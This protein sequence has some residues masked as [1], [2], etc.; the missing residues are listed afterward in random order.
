MPTPT[1]PSHSPTYKPND[2]PQ[3][4]S[5]SMEALREYFMRLDFYNRRIARTPITSDYNKIEGAGMGLQVFALKTWFAQGLSK[6]LAKPYT[7]FK[8]ELIRR[9]VPADFVWTQLAKLHRLRQAPGHDIDAFQEFSDQMRSLQM[10]IG[11]QVV[12]DQEVAKLVLLGTDPELCR[13][14]RTHMVS[15]LAGWSD[16][17][18]EKL[19]LDTPV[20]PTSPEAAEVFSDAHTDQPLEFD[21]QVFERIGREEWSRPTYSRPAAASAAPHV[22]TAATGHSPITGGP[23]P[24]A[25][26]TV[27]ERTYLDQNHGCYCRNRTAMC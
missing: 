8:S 17:P 24:V 7:Q 3:L 16:L 9:A 25:R 6:H 26:L 13:I 19:A 23:R 27:D 1:A 2:P 18:L 14:L 20:V 4:H 11:F 12:S 10:E 15:S 22:T 21:Y 5:T